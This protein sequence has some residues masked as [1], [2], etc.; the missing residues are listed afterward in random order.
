MKWIGQHIYDLVAR[1]R[2]DV[3]L[4]GLST[5]TETTALVVDSS[6]KVSKNVTSGVNLTNGADNR[7]VTALGTNGLQAETYFQF[8]AEDTYSLLQILD[9]T[10]T[11]GHDYFEIQVNANA[12]TWLKTVDNSHALAHLSLI[13]DGQI[14]L[15]AHAEI[16]LEV[17]DGEYIYLKNGSNKFGEFYCESGGQSYLRLFEMGGDSVTDYCQIGVAEHGATTFETADSAASN[18]HLTLQVDGHFYSKTASGRSFFYVTGND[19]DYCL[20][21]VGSNGDTTLSTVDAAGA[22]AHFEVA[23]DGNITLDAAGNIALEC[24]GGSL[25]CDADTV[26]FESAN[27]DDPI[28]T[29]KNTSNG[30]NDMA[31]L[32]MVK[33]RADNDVSSGTNVAEIY[34][35]GEDS[36]QNEQEYGRILCE[37]DV[38][39]DGQESGALKLG[40]A[41][42]DG[43]TAGRY[44]LQ[45]VGGSVEDE[46]DVTIADG[47]SSLTTISGG[48]T[49]NGKD[50]L[51]ESDVDGKPLVTIKTTNTTASASG[52][53]RFQ[54]D[55]DNTADGEYIGQISF[56]GEN[57]A[58]TPETLEYA[59]V[60]GA[61]GDQIDGQE[62]GQLYFGV[63]AYDGVLT[64]GL[65]I[66]G[67]TNAD[68]E[69]DVTIGTGSGSTTTITGSLELGHASDT[70]IARVGAGIAS[71]EGANIST[72]SLT[73]KILPSAFQVNDDAG[74][75]AFVEDDTSNTLGIRA[76]TTSD[77]LFAWK[78]IPAGFKVTHVQ[79]H[80]SASTSSAVT[81]LPYNYQTGATDNVSST[82][83]DFNENKAITNIPASATQDLVIAC[84]PASASTIIY[85][86]SVT[87]ALI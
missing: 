30:T 17:N 60:I 32:K 36:A 12:A 18:A 52:E 10:G 61:M 71:I 64:Q 27:A 83:A 55:A 77:E 41:S 85:G 67:N 26:T 43:E 65:L 42:H 76:Y 79:V 47:A 63:A 21:D 57:N 70:T 78:E 5:T 6:G 72:H 48:L 11:L 40:V 51:F 53:L 1:F 35:V 44:G 74:R 39:T 31:S 66:N 54:K 15:D 87:I 24:G 25:T 13:A 19:D 34:F 23:A 69:V 2:S 59:R 38:G 14:T 33:D 3:Y 37:I 80:A 29:I 28:V 86:A 62:A 56:Y 8:V 68:D 73:L 46:I 50:T 9:Y 84:A 81:I 16:N 49:V 22:A 7:V 4:E 82:T 58:G 45:M 20:L 75:P